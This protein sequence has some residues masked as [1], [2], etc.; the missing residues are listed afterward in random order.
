MQVHGHTWVRFPPSSCLSQGSIPFAAAALRS[1]I[2]LLRGCHFGPSVVGSTVGGGRGGAPRSPGSEAAV[3]AP[4]LSKELKKEN[5]TPPFPPDRKLPVWSD[6]A[7]R[8]TRGLAPCHHRGGGRLMPAQVI[9][10]KL[11]QVGVESSRVG[12]T[13]NPLMLLLLLVVVVA[14]IWAGS[15]ETPQHALFLAPAAQ[16][17]R[18][19]ALGLPTSSWLFPK[20]LE[21]QRRPSSA[22]APTSAE[23]RQGSIGWTT[24]LAQAASPAQRHSP[25]CDGGITVGSVARCFA[26]AAR[27]SGSPQG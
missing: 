16:Q 18:R 8:P 26:A 14:V 20:C 1:S 13:K 25:S 9:T 3:A 23:R 24:P 4:A 27:L 6:E 12:P 11:T 7:I 22:W 19:V 21:Q 5:G 10:G 15:A 17:P 2:C